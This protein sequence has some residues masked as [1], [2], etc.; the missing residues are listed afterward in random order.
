M[1]RPGPEML[2]RVASLAVLAGGWWWLRSSHAPAWAVSGRIWIRN[3]PPSYDNAAAITGASIIVIFL[4]AC[5]WGRFNPKWR[6]GPDGAMGQGCVV[7]MAYGLALLGVVHA[8]AW[9]FHVTFLIW[10]IAV[11]TVLPG[12]QLGAALIYEGFKAWRKR[13]RRLKP[14]NAS[15]S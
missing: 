12:I 3:R 5:L 11:I 14:V 6:G 8:I 2:L 4:A 13:A 7:F 15:R 10:L 1:R 9:Y